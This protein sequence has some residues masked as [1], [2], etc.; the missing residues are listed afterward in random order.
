MSAEREAMRRNL[1]LAIGGVASLA[2]LIAAIA[3][4]MWVKNSGKPAASND[5]AA[6][7][8][9]NVQNPSGAKRFTLRLGQG[10]R[11]KDGVVVVGKPDNQ[12]DI[13]F[14]Y[15]APQEAGQ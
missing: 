7:Q 14:K 8:A 2:L 12:P 9:S 11:F 6:V 3:L 1:L 13:V 10:F 4:L 5:T 15:L